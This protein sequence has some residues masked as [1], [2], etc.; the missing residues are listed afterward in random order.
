MS[1][2]MDQAFDKHFGKKTENPEEM[3][4]EVQHVAR[5]EPDAR[6]PC[7]AMGADGSANKKTRERTEGAAEAVQAVHGDSVSASRVDPSPRT[8]S[9]SFSVKA[10]PPLSLAGTT[11]WS[12]T[13]LRRLSR[14]SHPWKYA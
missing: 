6:Q 8:N 13:V 9:T 12:R 11:S 3:R 10:E 2:A 5:L 1:E 14:V 7:L 4:L